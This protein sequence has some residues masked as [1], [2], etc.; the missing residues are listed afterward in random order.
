MGAILTSITHVPLLALLM[1][2]AC[3]CMCCCM[4]CCLYFGHE[5]SCRSS[6]AHMKPM[7]SNA[8]LHTSSKV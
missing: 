6:F 5:A 4:V 7:G 2:H 1:A 8:S 3:R